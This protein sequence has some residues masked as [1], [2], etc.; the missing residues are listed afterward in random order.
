MAG[1]EVTTEGIHRKHILSSTKMKIM[2]E[3]CEALGFN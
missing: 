1:F 2:L 3:V